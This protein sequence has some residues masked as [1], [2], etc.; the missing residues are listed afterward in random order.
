MAN[1]EM[2]L[3]DQSRSVMYCPPPEAEDRSADYSSRLS[4]IYNI[5][6][7]DFKGLDNDEYW[8]TSLNIKVS[9]LVRKIYSKI[10]AIPEHFLNIDGLIEELESLGLNQYGSRTKTNWGM[11][12]GFNHPELAKKAQDTSTDVLEEP[13][14]TIRLRSHRRTGWVEETDP[15]AEIK[16]YGSVMINI[17]PKLVMHL[18]IP[19]IHEFAN[20]ILN[21]VVSYV[22]NQS[23]YTKRPRNPNPYPLLTGKI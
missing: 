15:E 6:N 5:D 23:N 18:R 3:N 19:Q 2:I 8:K 22:E 10:C 17:D 12:Y 9:A 16:Y 4:L 20:E 14:L 11:E 13:H 7:L 21:K 1:I